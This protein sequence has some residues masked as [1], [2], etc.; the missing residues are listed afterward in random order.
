MAKITNTT[1]D[2]FYIGDVEV[3]PHSTSEIDDKVVVQARRSKAITILFASGKLVIGEQAARH[4][5]YVRDHPN[6]V[7]PPAAIHY[8]QPKNLREFQPKPTPPAK[9]GAE[10]KPHAKLA[11]GPEPPKVLQEHLPHKLPEKQGE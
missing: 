4:E 7:G 8:K 10:V 1:D 3:K 9:V 2:L 11:K 6:Y 5:E